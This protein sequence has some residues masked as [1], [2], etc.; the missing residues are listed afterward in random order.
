MSKDE[1]RYLREQAERCRRLAAG[2][3]DAIAA[4][5]LRDM[6]VEYDERARAVAEPIPEPPAS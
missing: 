1:P 6:A 2:C 3:S 4:R 5:V